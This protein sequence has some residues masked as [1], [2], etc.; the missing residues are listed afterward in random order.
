MLQTIEAIVDTLGNVHL[1][2]PVHISGTRSAF[3]TILDEVPV[4]SSE[5]LLLSEQ[6]L[7]NDWNRPEED[8]AWAHLQ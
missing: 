4:E 1:R 8:E 5:M 2:E 7:A 3:V 6:A